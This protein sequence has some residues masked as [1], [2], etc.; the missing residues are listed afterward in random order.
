VIQYRSV[1]SADRWGSSDALFN[2]VSS[3]LDGVGVSGEVGSSDI[4]DPGFTTFLW[5]ALAAASAPACRIA[6]VSGVSSFLGAVVLG[7]RRP[8][9]GS[10]N[11]ICSNFVIDAGV[12]WVDV[13]REGGALEGVLVVEVAGVALTAWAAPS[14]SFSSPYSFHSSISSKS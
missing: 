12:A 9:A 4:S 14:C 8:S 5:P 3:A 10:W 1:V 2:F 6:K 11:C 13:P 7:L